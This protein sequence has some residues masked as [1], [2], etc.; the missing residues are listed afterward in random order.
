MSLK[1]FDPR[2]L[3]CVERINTL[4]AACRDAGIRPI[5]IKENHRDSM[6]DFGRELDG[7]ETVH[8]LESWHNADF[9]DCLDIREE[10]PKIPKRRYSAFNRT[11]LDIILNGLGVYPGDTLIL[12]GYLTDVCVHYTAVDAHQSDYRFKVVTDCCGGSTPRAHEYAI[13]A[14]HYLQH[15]A[16]MTLEE[17]LKEIAEYKEAHAND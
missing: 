16:D 8:C 2:N 5:F 3:E 6:V 14:M 7:T 4:L 11:D 12:C 10:D 13:E 1:W 15:D 17:I 9:A